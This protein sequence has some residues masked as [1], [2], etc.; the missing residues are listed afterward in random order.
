[1]VFCCFCLVPLVFNG[2]NVPQCPLWFPMKWVDYL[3]NKLANW[4]S[5]RLQVSHSWAVPSDS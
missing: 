2:S 3:N 4:L 5:E 1:M